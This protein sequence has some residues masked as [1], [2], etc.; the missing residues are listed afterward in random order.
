MERNTRQNV[1]LKSSWTV[2]DGLR[3]HARVSEERSPEGPPAVILVHGLVV[4]SRYMVPTLRQLAPH[5]RVYAP[6]LPGFGKSTNPSRV[7]SAS[8]LSDALSA[9][10]R[11]VGLKSAVLVGNSFG[12]QIIADLATRHPERVERVVLQGP[13]MDPEGRS[14]LR[15]IARFLLNVSREPLSLNPIMLL[16]ALDAG[17]LR[18]WRTFRYALKNRN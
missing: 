9:W 17:L 12:C 16:D 8:G 10:M 15:Q 13:T 6:D 1:K 2:V 3:M 11:A 7:L 5:Y 18:R 14:V 4:S